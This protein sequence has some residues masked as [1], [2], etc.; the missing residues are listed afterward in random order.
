M[1][2]VRLIALDLDG[3]LLNSKKE[4]TPRSYAALES[5]AAA[6]IEIVP[7]TGRFHKGMPEVIRA[8]PFV[9]YVI[10]INGAQVVDIRSGET[11]YSADIPTDEALAFYEY[12][13][14]LPVIYDAY[15]DGWG[16]MTGAMQE[17][18]EGFGMLPFQLV[19]MRELRS[20]VPE[21]KEYIRAGRRKVQ[22]MQLFTPDSAL[23]ERLLAALPG[24]YPQYAISA[25]LPNNIEIN[26]RD[27][28]K[29]RALR[30]LA[31]HLG[32]DIAQ[33]MAFGDGLNDLAMLRAAG[34]GVAM[35]NAHPDVKAAADRIAPDCDSDGVAIV[36]EELL[37]GGIS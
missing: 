34:V 17:A 5:A 12:L 29:G 31:K 27:A 32:L 18:L 11:V 13:D 37:Q 7:A 21:L 20:P 14:T 4:L 30:E 19:M 25:S 10:T 1:P 8:L 23:R 15:I 28:D 26:S 6:G 9:R 3:T 35:D 33:T 2:D 22:K 16:Y 24:K 36:I